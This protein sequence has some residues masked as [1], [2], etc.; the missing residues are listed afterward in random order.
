[1]V[2][3]RAY[4]ANSS[5]D[6]VSVIDTAT[7]TVVATVD[8]GDGPVGVAITPDGA[9]AYVANF[10]SDDVSVIDTATNTVVA[11]V[12]VGDG[13][14]GV[15][16][17]PAAVDS[18]TSSIDLDDT[19][20]GNGSRAR[21]SATLTC[22]A[23]EVFRL[24]VVLTQAGATGSGST[25]GTCTGAPQPVSVGV[26][27]NPGPSFSAGDVEAEATLETADPGT[28]TINDTTMSTETLTY[29]IP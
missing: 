19:V 18:P 1:A 25:R 14:Q 29:T 3:N 11:T 22:P 20:L 4:V 13:P 7:D 9:R 16:I 26:T 24:S 5:S 2:P 27:T 8:V 17:T 28:K 10:N 15:A 12:D 23:G 6:D 21:V